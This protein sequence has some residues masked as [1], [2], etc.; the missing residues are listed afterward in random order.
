M[1]FVLTLVFYVYMGKVKMIRFI[2]LTIV[3][4]T[5]TG[6]YDKP[7]ITSAPW[8]AIQ[9]PIFEPAAITLD[10][11]TL[12][13]APWEAVLYPWERYDEDIVSRPPSFEYVVKPDV[14][15][16]IYLGE[17]VIGNKHEVKWN[18]ENLVIAQLYG[19]GTA[20]TYRVNT[21][22]NRATLEAVHTI[23]T[24]LNRQESDRVAQYVL[25]GEEVPEELRNKAKPVEVT[26]LCEIVEPPEIRD[27]IF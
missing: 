19:V 27:R 20:K 16:T 26:V 9:L 11:S 3:L 14:N 23:P 8:K 10:C 22:I 7:A 12:N 5:L 13:R 24:R 15:E 21:V 1:D 25:T 17:R 6:C 2:F 4:A 18:Y